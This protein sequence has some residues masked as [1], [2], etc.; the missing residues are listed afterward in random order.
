MALVLVLALVRTLQGISFFLQ[1]TNSNDL[2]A[3]IKA[4]I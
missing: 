1:V 3:I 2:P 4:E